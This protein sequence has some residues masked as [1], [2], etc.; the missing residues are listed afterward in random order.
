MLDRLDWPALVQVAR[1]LGNESLPSVKPEGEMI[2]DENLLQDLH[3]LL[4]ETCITEGEMTCQSCGHVYYIKN[5]I[6]NFLLPPH[7]A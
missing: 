2:N 7:L 5:S 6:P 4:L 1:D 3:T